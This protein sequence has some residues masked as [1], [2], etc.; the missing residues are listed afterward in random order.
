ME[1]KGSL[2]RIEEGTAV[3]IP[4]EKIDDKEEFLIPEKLLYEGAKEG[5]RVHI[6]ID[7]F[8]QTVRSVRFDI[9]RTRKAQEQIKAKMAKLNRVSKRKNR[10]NTRGN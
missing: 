2:D 3:L 8:V 7:E 1:V 6:V 5:D 10:R 9:E 4:D